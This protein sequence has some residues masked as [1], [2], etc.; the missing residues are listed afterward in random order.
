MR[1]KAIFPTLRDG[2]PDDKLKEFIWDAPSDNDVEALEQTF[3]EF[4]VVEEGNNHIGRRC[5]SMSTGDMAVCIDSL[6]ERIYIVE[7]IGWRLVDSETA[8]RW[9]GTPYRDRCLRLG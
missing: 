2:R 9:M 3:R 7:P 6:G 8:K 1:V 5:R 4:N